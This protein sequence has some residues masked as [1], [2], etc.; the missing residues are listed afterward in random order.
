[1]AKSKRTLNLNARVPG[2]P[3]ANGESR[4]GTAFSQPP[5]PRPLLS[6]DELE[7]DKHEDDGLC[8]VDG[9]PIQALL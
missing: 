7:H 6:H 5:A 3:G 9:I 2:G 8:A 4:T 1:L